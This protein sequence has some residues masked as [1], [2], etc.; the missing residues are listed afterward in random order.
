MMSKI[1]HKPAT[2]LRLAL[3]VGASASAI[4][5]ATPAQAQ[6]ACL[7]DS[8]TE[9]VPNG[10]DALAC[11]PGTTADGEESVA[12]GVDSAANG[13]NASAI[14]YENLAD[15][16]GASALGGENEAT[17][18]FATAT[19]WANTASGENS[20]ASGRG[21]QA[22]GLNSVALGNQSQATGVS[23]VAIGDNAIASADNSVA[24]GT[25]SVA[26][27]ANTV[28]VGSA[29]Q[30][31]RITNVAAGTGVTDAVNLGQL[32]SQ[33]LLFQQNLDAQA[34]AFNQGL[35]DLDFRLEE[36][37]RD[38]DAG[39]AGAMA[40]ASIPQATSAGSSTLGFGTATWGGEVAFSFG[41][42]HAF[43]NGAV[44]IVGATVDGR[45]RGGANAGV[46]FQF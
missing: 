38:A 41:G 23:A 24:L 25:G 37:S 29:T 35:A 34:L 43:E 9:V 36:V 1:E 5:F 32:N 15:G 30:Q 21:N 27:A 8:G 12:V 28:S 40:V 16:F 44:V 4:V 46:G 7:L 13:L 14:G 20:L 26:S 39:I 45:G 18:Q 2:M 31:R 22:T 10:T 19:G 42:S 6:D 33:A 11:G 17:A 3:L